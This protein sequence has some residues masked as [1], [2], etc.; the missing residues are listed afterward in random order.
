VLGRALGAESF[1]YGVMGYGTLQQYMI[2][3]RY[4]DEIQPGLIILQMCSNDLIN[5]SLSVEIAR[6]RQ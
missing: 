4:L 5:N 2:L 1:A 3:D 6:D